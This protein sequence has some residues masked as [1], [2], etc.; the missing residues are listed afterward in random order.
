MALHNNFSW[1]T[2]RE[3]IDIDEHILYA[4]SLIAK[5]KWSG[6]VRAGLMAQ[7]DKIK[8]KQ[9]DTALNLSV[10]G[11]FSTGKS[12]FINALLGEQL[13]VS[14]VIQGT[15][16]VNT[17]IEYCDRPCICVMYRDGRY[18]VRDFSAII[19]LSKELSILTTD[20]K[21]ARGIKIIR[22]G[23]PSQ[24]LKSGIRIIDTPGTNSLESWHEDVTREALRDLS[25]LSIILTDATHPLPVTLTDFMMEN[26]AD[27]YTQCAFVATYYD[28]V[29]K[30][31][32]ADVLRYIT[33]KLSTEF[34]IEEPVVLP[35]VAPA[36]MARNSGDTDYDNRDEFA[37]LSDRS[38]ETLF[39]YMAR[40][41]QIAQIKKVLA[42][43]SEEF[44]LLDVSITQN[45]QDLE[46]KLDL[47]YKSKRTDLTSFIGL[48]K[49][50]AVNDYAMENRSIRMELIEKCEK[51]ISKSKYNL[52]NLIRSKQSIE[53]LK[54]F[55][56]NEFAGKCEEEAKAVSRCVE[57]VFPD[58]MALFNVI[59]ENFQEAFE[60]EFKKLGILKVNFNSKSTEVSVSDRGALT[61]LKDATAYVSKELSKENWAAAG[62]IAAAITGAAIGSAI[63]VVGTIIG[64]IIGL[65]AGSFM[66][67]DDKKVIN[68]LVQKV[69]PQLD[70]MFAKV[71]SDVLAAFDAN[72]DRVTEAIGREIDR[73]LAEY[74]SI[75]DRQLKE[76]LDRSARLQ[77]EIR[78]VNYDLRIIENHKQQLLSA[79][80]K[81]TQ[82]IHG[83][84]N[85]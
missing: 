43:A 81:I 38:A 50:V 85:K 37:E 58:Q 15:T 60:K 1:N 9:R 25:D 21:S 5:Y 70:A 34:D 22:V 53:E 2:V 68:N 40:K 24:L 23:I 65:F 27:I 56:Q 11:E 26:L 79:S 41:R 52:K 35:Y 59:I 30:R 72:S 10:V 66:M 46:R 7:L 16:V 69:S 39:R 78:M 18:E 47:L 63:P 8:S 82:Y 83:Y 20:R 55:M 77:G 28:M 76:Y 64:G 6:N 54:N 33:R 19:A 61:N 84:G 45:K 31:E 57:D 75:V 48:Q 73:Y 17:V 4:E 80:D 42:L 71:E 67:P 3:F 36:V 44:S 74:K 13:L 29:P 62:T 12:S 14:S 32:R 51:R 49:T